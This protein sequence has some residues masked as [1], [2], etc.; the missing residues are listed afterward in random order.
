MKRRNTFDPLFMG[1]FCGVV[2]LISLASGIVGLGSSEDT[3]VTVIAF[4]VG[5]SLVAFGIVEII[6]RVRA[7]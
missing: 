7:K 6:I 3:F 1:V 5:I 2:G 4:V